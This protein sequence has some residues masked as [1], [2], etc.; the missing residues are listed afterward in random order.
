MRFLTIIKVARPGP[1]PGLAP[2]DARWRQNTSAR[3]KRHPH[4][5]IWE[6]GKE[7]TKAARSRPNIGPGGALDAPDAGG[8]PALLV[9]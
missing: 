8:A 5:D 3:P 1:A 4:R 6:K 7:D 9:G 2:M